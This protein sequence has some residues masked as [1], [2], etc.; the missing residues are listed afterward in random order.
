[1]TEHL[2]LPEELKQRLQQEATR[3]G[4]TSEQLAAKVLDAHLPKPMTPLTE[5]RLQSLQEMLTEWHAEDLAM[6][7]E[8]S[9]ANEEVLR[10]IDSH[11]THRKLFQE[12]LS[13]KD[14]N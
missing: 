12:Y 9:A 5:E 3:R 1:M 7:E 4:T 2:K 8:E 6:T 14:T 10:Q 13:H 11:R